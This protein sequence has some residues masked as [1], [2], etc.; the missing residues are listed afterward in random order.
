MQQLHND[1]RRIKDATPEGA[2]ARSLSHQARHIELPTNFD[3]LQDELLDRTGDVP[4][5]NVYFRKN[6]LQ[7]RTYIGGKQRT[8]FYG[9]RD[10]IVLGCLLADVLTITFWPFRYAYDERHPDAIPE[11]LL[12]FGMK[13]VLDTLNGG[14]QCGHDLTA[15]RDNVLFGVKQFGFRRMHVPLDSD[16]VPARRIPRTLTA[17]FQSFRAEQDE[18]SLLVGQGMIDINKRLDAL[19]AAVEKILQLAISKQ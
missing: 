11:D 10:D 14:D 12:N 19:C 15:W 18:R 9:T 13:D 16:G 17:E 8:F 4:L 1:D 3:S 6:R 5:R 2:W 7:V